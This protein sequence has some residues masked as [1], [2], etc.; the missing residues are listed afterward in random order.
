M[1]KRKCLSMR[2]RICRRTI[3]VPSRFDDPWRRIPQNPVLLFV[4]EEKQ[5]MERHRWQLLIHRNGGLCREDIR[6]LYANDIESTE[7]LDPDVQG[8]QVQSNASTNTTQRLHKGW[9]RKN[10]KTN[11]FFDGEWQCWWHDEVEYMLHPCQLISSIEHVSRNIPIKVRRHSGIQT[12]CNCM[13]LSDPQ[14][15][16]GL[17][18]PFI[19]IFLFLFDVVVMKTN[20]FGTMP[21]SPSIGIYRKRCLYQLMG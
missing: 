6:T 7:P 12:I 13:L 5:S 21:L 16:L 9:K 11:T 18:F 19:I 14:T 3:R 15:P 20:T 4:Y 2:V 17:C 8:P 1:F 10:N